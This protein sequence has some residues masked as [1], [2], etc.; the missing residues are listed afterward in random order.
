MRLKRKSRPQEDVVDDAIRPRKDRLTA[1]LSFAQ[2]RLWFLHQLDPFNAAY[3]LPL[4]YRLTGR[5][6]IR[7]LEHS[8]NE[9]IRRHEVLRTVFSE[10]DG[11]AVQ[12][13]WPTLKVE[14]PV[15]DLSVASKAEREREVERLID[16]EADRPFSLEAGP[17]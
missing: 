9:I 16:Q 3:H 13:V 12:I 4:Y 10:R 17:L 2:Q 6:N 15:I 1:P 11:T 8:L 14:L 7:A 5:L